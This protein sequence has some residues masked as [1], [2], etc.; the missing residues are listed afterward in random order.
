VIIAFPRGSVHGP[1]GLSAVRTPI[2]PALL[3]KYKKNF[4]LPFITLCV[5]AGAHELLAHFAAPQDP[6]TG[7]SP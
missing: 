3:A 1:I 6:A 7:I 4:S 5:A 2:L